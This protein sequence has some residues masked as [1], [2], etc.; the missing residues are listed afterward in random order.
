MDKLDKAFAYI[1]ES[2]CKAIDMDTLRIGHTI[3]KALDKQRDRLVLHER[4]FWTYKH[5]C[6]NCCMLLE[7]EAM[8]HC[9]E[10]GQKLDWS[11]YEEG[12]KY[13]R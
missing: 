12:L 8:R 2:M 11:N 9:S 4:T 6:P 10:C 7:R 1:Q 5:Y 3:T 13:V